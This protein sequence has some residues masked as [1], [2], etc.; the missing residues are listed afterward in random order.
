MV[1]IR[2]PKDMSAEQAALELKHSIDFGLPEVWLAG[3]VE[4]ETDERAAEI[5]AHW[6]P[7]AEILQG[8]GGEP[9][10]E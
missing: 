1:R 10:P 4:S 6:K 8:T 5:R 3:V 2:I 7:V 9:R